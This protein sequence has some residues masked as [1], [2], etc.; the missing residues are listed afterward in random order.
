M[1]K[2][3]WDRVVRRHGLG[4]TVAYGGLDP[5][6]ELFLTPLGE[7]FRIVQHGPPGREQ[8]LCWPIIELFRKLFRFAEMK[9]LSPLSIRGT[10]AHRLYERGADEEQVGQVMGI[11]DLFQV[12][13]SFPRPKVPWERLTR[14]L[15]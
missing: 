1:D 4:S 7:R 11:S 10:L 15:F 2:Y 12:S 13:E 3:L 8:H 9:Y 5:T 6:S 14:E